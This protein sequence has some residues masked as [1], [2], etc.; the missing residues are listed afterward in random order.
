MSKQIT[1]RLS[2]VAEKHFNE[3]YFTLDLPNKSASQSDA[4]NHCLE[5]CLMFEEIMEDQITNF[6]MTNYPEKYDAWIIK[7]NIKQYPNE[8]MD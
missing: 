3:V 6:I 7:H 4:V 1:V 5:E 8:S 2:E